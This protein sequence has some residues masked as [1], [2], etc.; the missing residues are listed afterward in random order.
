MLIYCERK[1]LLAQANMLAAS[2]LLAMSMSL[3]LG[4]AVMPRWDKVSSAWSTIN[5]W[6]LPVHEL[7][8][9]L[10]HMIVENEGH[11]RSPE[12]SPLFL[13]M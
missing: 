1:I 10:L 11:L 4:G 6:Q 12:S 13:P 9:D 3:M 5:A 2:N 7:D 8:T